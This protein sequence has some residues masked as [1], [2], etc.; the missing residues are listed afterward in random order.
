[1]ALHIADL[2]NN[3]RLGELRTI[4]NARGAYAQLIRKEK[5]A[6]EKAYQRRVLSAMSIRCP[7]CALLVTSARCE[8]CCFYPIPMPSENE[9]RSREDSLRVSKG[10]PP[11]HTTVQSLSRRGRETS[12]SAAH[13]N[14]P[15]QD[16][17]NARPSSAA[18]LE[19]LEHIVSRQ[20]D[21]R[22]GLEQ[23][24]KNIFS[25]V[26]QLDKNKSTGKN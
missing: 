14:A 2:Y 1:M 22:R 9:L 8:H 26:E 5:L 25:L 11:L 17:M 19:A 4:E 15:Q 18:R 16:R 20:R 24:L 21:E 3:G 6:V 13:L 10:L 23:R 12:P 7:R